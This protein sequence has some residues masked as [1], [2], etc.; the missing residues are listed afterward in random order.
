MATMSHACMDE[1]QRIKAEI[2]TGSSDSACAQLREELAEATR[3]A[4]LQEAQL[5]QLA[6]Q[7]EADVAALSKLETAGISK[8]EAKLAQQLTDRT[9]QF[10]A[11]RCS[12]MA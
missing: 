1:L 10:E 6:A 3:Q 9:I 8:R 7:H 12:P 11:N 2:E 4:A 5:Q